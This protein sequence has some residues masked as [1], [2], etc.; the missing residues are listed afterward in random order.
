MS[1]SFNK[2]QQAIE[3]LL[4]R[5]RR[6]QEKIDTNRSQRAGALERFDRV[7]IEDGDLEPLQSE[8]EKLDS[9][10]ELLNRQAMT[11][12]EADSSE[13]MANLAQAVLAENERLLKKLQVEWQQQVESL[14]KCRKQYL[15][16]V[17][18]ASSIYKKGKALTNEIALARES[19]PKRGESRYI[20]GVADSLNL[21]RL[22]GEIFFDNERI[23]QA[24]K[25]A[26]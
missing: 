24:F 23:K 10:F 19:L 26:N 4:A 12:S 2:Y 18:K 22:R 15:R 9:E 25:E 17:R 7:A 1:E 21:D 5:Q 16:T 11:L 20:P 13:Y 14:Q 3:N 8:I 6:V